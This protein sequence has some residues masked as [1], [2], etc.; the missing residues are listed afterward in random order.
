MDNLPK[1]TTKSWLWQL[2][3]YYG[4]V[5]DVFISKKHRRSNKLMFAFVRFSQLQEA[6]SLVR[7][8]Q[9]MVIRSTKLF[10]KMAGY[11]R[12]E[13][14]NMHPKVQQGDMERN[15]KGVIEGGRSYKG[16]VLQQST[17]TKN[18][19]SKDD[20]GKEKMDDDDPDNFG[21]PRV[22]YS[23]V[24]QYLVKELERSVVGESKGPMDIHE[25]EAFLK[26]FVLQVEKVRVM[27]AY[28]TLITF[29]TKE[30]MWEV[31]KHGDR[32]FG[33]LFDEVRA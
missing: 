20:K 7:N 18:M 22:V 6:E 14:K 27:G 31:L 10:L 30:D 5:I 33:D 13:E 1:S 9:G 24:N 21:K 17:K 2:V 15:E 29:S 4:R 12:N 26:D 32:F 3:N 19:V 25:M 8:L 11:K 28:K 16:A 23:E